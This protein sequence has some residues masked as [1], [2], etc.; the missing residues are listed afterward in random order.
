MLAVP[1]ALFLLFRWIAFKRE[2]RR[3]RSADEEG[4]GDVG[5]RE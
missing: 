3:S 5:G 4:A 2:E 1:V